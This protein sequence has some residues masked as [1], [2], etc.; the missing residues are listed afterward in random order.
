MIK[1]NLEEFWKNFV[2]LKKFY[3]FG[4]YKSII[5]LLFVYLI[6]FLIFFYF[7][8]KNTYSYLILGLMAILYFIFW[9][10]N[11]KRLFFDKDKVNILI[12]LPE[13]NT[14]SEIDIF[15]RLEKKILE[16]I[17]IDDLTDTFNIKTSFL[18][19]PNTIKKAHQL[20][21]HLNIQM[22]IWA[23]YDA[24][25][26]EQE[27][28]LEP[29]FYF[30]Y[31]FPI[32]TKK[33]D[34]K[35]VAYNIAPAFLNRN[36]TI[37]EENDVVDLNI[38]SSQLQEISLYIISI[39]L[40][41]K[42]K[43]KKSLILLNKINTQR[44]NP[45][46]RKKIYSLYKYN[47][48]RPVGL[49]YHTLVKKFSLPNIPLEE[50]NKLEKLIDEWGRFNKDLDYYSIII[51][52][53][54]LKGEIEKSFKFA[55]KGKEIFNHP[56]FYLDLGFLLMYQNKIVEGMKKYK[57]AFNREI[58]KKIVKEAI[59][60]TKEFAKGKNKESLNKAIALMNQY[61]NTK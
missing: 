39:S 50:L 47:H 53:Y 30:T 51:I 22:I 59:W 60:F 13:G 61:L 9:M 29:R 35:R 24:G 27:K 6:F 32:I 21:N 15:R 37:R 45:I 3:T 5:G 19:C 12:A 28:V 8:P 1:I 42:G 7:S 49:K 38:I 46:F 16:L 58:D 54:F 34:I 4:I 11:R 33:K 23:K 41:I 43:N 57:K 17:K 26:K 52:L 44:I 55:K 10:V 20:R 25:K 56:I 31:E 36:W 14:Q 48:S 18:H 40:A 2:Y